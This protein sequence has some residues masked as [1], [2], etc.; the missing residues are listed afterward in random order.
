MSL[1]DKLAKRV[2]LDV[3]KY[4]AAREA[5]YER[6]AAAALANARERAA[7][8]PPLYQCPHCGESLDGFVRDFEDEES[9]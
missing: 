4:V 3:E 5:E 9:W 1:F 7:L 6:A 8:P 2:N